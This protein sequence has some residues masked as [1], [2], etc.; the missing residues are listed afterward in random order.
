MALPAKHPYTVTLEPGDLLTVAEFAAL[1]PDAEGWRTELIEGRVIRMPPVKDARHD[2]ITGNLYMALESYARPRGLGRC[3]LQQVGYAL[4][5]AQK[6]PGK[7]TAPDVAFVRAEHM[8]IVRAAIVARTYV[9]LAP[10][11]AAEIVSP[12][13]ATERDMQ[14][15]AA[16]WLEAGTRLVWNIWPDEEAIDIWAPDDEPQRLTIGD[17]LTGADVLPGFSLPVADLFA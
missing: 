4:T 2:W 11:I 14:D 3:T 13:Q 16:L 12:S 7:A 17:L 9:E 5:P 8:P 1:P 10:D 15:R 6:K